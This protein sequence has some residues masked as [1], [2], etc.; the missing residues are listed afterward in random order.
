VR[1]DSARDYCCAAGT[2]AWSVSAA[3]GWRS[4][5]TFLAATDNPW[6][7]AAAATKTPEG[8]RFG[9]SRS[10]PRARCILLARCGIS[11]EEFV[12]P[13]RSLARRTCS[14]IYY[15]R[16]WVRACRIFAN[17]KSVKIFDSLLFTRGFDYSTG[18][19]NCVSALATR[20]RIYRFIGIQ[21]RTPIIRTNINVKSGFFQP[22]NDL[23]SW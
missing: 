23:L 5:V 13:L 16:R 4:S 22:R 11:G 3:V 20:V 8:C 6:K 18:R 10:A 19:F 14:I 17:E 9:G 12:H 1:G 21:Y 7:T 2:V 15:I